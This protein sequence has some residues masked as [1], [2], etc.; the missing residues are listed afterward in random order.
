ME[1]W[2][3]GLQRWLHTCSRTDDKRQRQA[4]VVVPTLQLQVQLSRGARKPNASFEAGDYVM[5]QQLTDKTLEAPVRPHVLCIVAVKSSVVVL[6]KRS[7]GARCEEQVKN[8][9]H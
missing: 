8:I 6:M 5:I 4:A 1:E 7:D 9:A 3:Q 2:Q